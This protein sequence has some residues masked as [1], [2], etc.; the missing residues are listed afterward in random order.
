VN[1][2]RGGVGNAGEGG[3]SN[4]GGPLNEGVALVCVVLKEPFVGRRPFFCLV[5]DRSEFDKMGKSREIREG[6]V[7]LLGD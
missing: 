2:G 5:L 6:D 4:S 7:L 1:I 3:S